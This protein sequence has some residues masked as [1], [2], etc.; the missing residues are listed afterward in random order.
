MFH[1]CDLCDSQRYPTTVCRRLPDAPWTVPRFLPVLCGIPPRR[2]SGDRARPAMR[3]RSP[4]RTLRVRRRAPSVRRHCAPPARFGHGKNR[5]DQAQWPDAAS[6][7]WVEPPDRSAQRSPTEDCPRRT[8]CASCREGR[9]SPPPPAA[10]SRALPAAEARRGPWPVVT[11][12]LPARPE[13]LVFC[14]G[15]SPEE[16]PASR[17]RRAAG[18][19]PGSNGAT[20]IPEAGGRCRL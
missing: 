20:G 7:P 16:P 5:D 3:A 15:L 12:L 10:P 18:D 14:G 1:F 13:R 11:A 6:S 19:E 4:L 8:L 2:V 17:G 9:V